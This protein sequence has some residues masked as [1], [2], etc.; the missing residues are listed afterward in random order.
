MALIERVV[1]KAV[2]WEE[3]CGDETPDTALFPAEE[4]LLARASERR[5][6]DFT[7]GRDC[8]H[9]ALRRLGVEPGAIVSGPAGEPRWPAGVIGSITH[10]EGYRAAAVGWA[11]DVPA[12]GIDAEPNEPLPAG[13]LAAVAGPEEQA[14]IRRLT[15]AVR[16]VCVDR[17]LFSAKEALYKAWYPYGQRMLSF[18]EAVVEL[19]TDGTLVGRLLVPGPPVDGQELRGLVGR[20]T[21]GQGLVLTAMTDLLL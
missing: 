3:A 6:R 14:E 1:P 17:L 10:C 11:A 20:W 8:A 16:G 21:A 13:V 7:G 9:R 12:L 15:A 19:G 5:R 4:A 2:V 18:E